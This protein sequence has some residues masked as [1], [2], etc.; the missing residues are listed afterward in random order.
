M[1]EID[2]QNK[3]RIAKFGANKLFEVDYNTRQ[4]MDNQQLIELF[5]RVWLNELRRLVLNA[6]VIEPE[7]VSRRLLDKHSS[8][9]DPQQEHRSFR[10]RRAEFIAQPEPYNNGQ[11]KL[12]QLWRV[13]SSDNYPKTLFIRHLRNRI[14]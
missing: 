13:A 6:E 9:V 4:R 1:I 7:E 2:A 3:I 5:D 8:Y 14:K 12:T 10:Y 11:Y